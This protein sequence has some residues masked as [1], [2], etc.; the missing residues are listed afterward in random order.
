MPVWF[1]FCLI[2]ARVFNRSINYRGFLSLNFFAIELNSPPRQADF[3]DM[4]AALCS[5]L[6]ASISCRLRFRLYLHRSCSIFVSRRKACSYLL[7]LI[8]LLAPIGAL[9]CPQAST[10]TY[11]LTG[12]LMRSPISAE[13]SGDGFAGDATGDSGE[14]P[15]DADTFNDR[16]ADVLLD[17]GEYSQLVDECA[18]ILDRDQDCAWARFYRGCA[19]FQQHEYRAAL[20][21][22]KQTLCDSYY[23]R[24]SHIWLGATYE[25]IRKYQSSINHYSEAI[26]DGDSDPNLLVSRGCVIGLTGRWGEAIED[27]DR[28]L[29][30]Q[31]NSGWALNNRGYA[32]AKL[33][34]FDEALVDLSSAIEV[35]PD[36]ANSYNYRGYI[37]QQRKELDAA[38]ADLNKAIEIAP[39]YAAAYMNRGC[40]HLLRDRRPIL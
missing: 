37:H 34:A 14:E 17:A 29:A 23:G 24:T 30:L 35:D 2:E 12:S 1:R 16:K 3:A 36:S 33:G 28:A 40:A 5:R 31:P 18:R 25:R 15:G 27:F 8:F 20:K 39:D 4:L 10:G 13:E 38:I 6:L 26:K 11:K 32:R 21:D 7:T 9:A 22:F 19:N